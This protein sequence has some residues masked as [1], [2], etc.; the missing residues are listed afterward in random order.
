MAFPR[1]A[2][3]CFCMVI[4]AAIA[5]GQWQSG[6]TGDFAPQRRLHTRSESG[7]RTIVVETVEGR[8]IEGRV[9]PIGEVVTETTRT[10]DATHTR[11][12][13]FRVMADGRRRLEESHESREDAPSNGN[14]R[15]VHSN[16][17][18][19][20][21]GRLRLTSQLLE[22]TRSPAADVRQTDT[23]LLL[24]GVDV[25]GPLREALRTEYTERE[26]SPG[27]VRHEG[28][29]LI[30]D[31]NG[32]WK[33]IEIRRGEVRRAGTSERLE[34][35]TVQ[36]PDLSGNL[37]V[38]E[39]NLTRSSTTKER[40]QVTIQTYS[41]RT[42]VYTLDGRPPLSMRVQRTTTATADGGSYTV[43]EVEARS[44]VSPNEPMRLVRRIVTSVSKSGP[45]DWVTERQIF[46]LD[47]N[48][49][50]R[51]VKVE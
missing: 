48:G 38:K 30:R 25:D 28:A 35:E 24:P 21:N 31:V 22:E 46:E 45:D 43:E 33:P 18:P 26:I 3:I 40:E 11:Q 41:P 2:G 5:D 4:T 1:I 32:R 37:V 10:R 12:D 8:N 17:V 9:G 7:G 20:L 19:D 29:Q 39:V 16:W 47:P 36:R 44:R 50:L 27:V 34:E 42:D 51:L 6:A 13:A 49:R 23:T 14:T 15:A